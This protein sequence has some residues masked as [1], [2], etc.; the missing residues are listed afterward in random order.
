MGLRA[1]CAPRPAARSCCSPGTT[2]TR[3]WP[4]TSTCRLTSC[5][6][7]SEAMTEPTKACGSSG[8][9]ELQ[10][11]RPDAEGDGTGLDGQP[12]REVVAEAHG[13]AADADGG[14]AVALQRRGDQVHLRRADEAGDEG[15]LRP[16]VER[17]RVGDLHD[18]A[19]LHHA[20]PVAHGHRL[21]LVVGDVDDGGRAALLAQAAVQ[22]GDP[23]PH[24]GA[25]LGV[26]VRQRLVE[27]EDLGLLDQRPAD[28]DA[29]G[30]AARELLR[31]PVEQRLDLEDARDLVGGLARSRASACGAA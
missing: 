8:S 11:L 14:R 20:D 26:E 9:R 28:G 24:R 18:A 25:K 2:A 29:L 23:H 16:L 4:S 19:L 5:P 17:G 21:G 6:M 12:P 31:Q 27:Q 3:T 10:V 13:L 30:L 1:T 22:V 7:N 15:V